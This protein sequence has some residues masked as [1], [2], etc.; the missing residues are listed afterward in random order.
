MRPHRKQVDNTQPEIKLIIQTQLSK[1]GRIYLFEFSLCFVTQHGSR[2]PV[3]RH[4]VIKIFR[5]LL[6][7]FRLLS[8][9]GGTYNQH[10]LS[11]V[12]VHGVS[13]HQGDINMAKRSVHRQTVPTSGGPLKRGTTVLGYIKSCDIIITANMNL[14]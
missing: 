13:T 14:P 4:L 3:R 9:L 10:M 12:R 8:A 1:L 7:C 2:R 5:Y 11:A 6:P